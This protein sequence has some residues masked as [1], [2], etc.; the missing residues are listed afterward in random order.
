MPESIEKPFGSTVLR[1]GR[2]YKDLVVLDADLQ[3]ATETQEFAETFP[4][5]YFNVGVSE[6]NMIGIAAGLAL[7]GKTVF[8]GTFSCFITQRVYDQ[9]AISVAYT[10][11]SVKLFG[12]EPALTSGNNGATH[13]S[14]MDLAIMRAMPGMTVYDPLDGNEFRALMEYQATHP[15]PAYV[16][17][18]RKTAPLLIDSGDNFEPG[19]VYTLKQG[20]DVSIITCGIM[21]PYCME[22][23]EEL[24]NRGISVDLLATSSIKPL[25]A[26]Q[27]IAS[28]KR[29]H[30][31]VSVENHS[32]IGGLGGAICEILSVNY[33][34]PIIRIGIQDQFGE[35]GSRDWLF[36][37][38]QMD[39]KAIA[40]AAEKAM[41]LKDKFQES[42][43]AR[44]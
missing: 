38:F 44:L 12:F 15:E 24:N 35:I 20:N 18:F 28:V 9:V 7:S 4:D 27:I 10:Q 22:V 21:L 2:D 8:C 17:A 41:Q 31:L 11:T 1:L 14:V 36:G 5:R 40:L 23:S 19:K 37:K 39:K 13:Q 32:I 30:C 43:N 25:Q 26:E 29:T 34:V 3:R 42:G 16:R 6:A 33:P